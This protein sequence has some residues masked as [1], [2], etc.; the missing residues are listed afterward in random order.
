MHR[1]TESDFWCDDMLSRYGRA[2]MHSERGGGAG[3][4]TSQ[5]WQ[6]GSAAAAACSW[7]RARRRDL[8]VVLGTPYRSRLAS[9]GVNA[10]GFTGPQY[11]TFRGPSMCWTPTIIPTQSRVRCTIFIIDFVVSAV[12]EQVYSSTCK[13]MKSVRWNASLFTSKCTKTRL[14]V[15]LC[16]DPLGELTALPRSPSWVKWKGNRKGGKEGGTMRGNREGERKREDPQCL[17]CVDAN[18]GQSISLTVPDRIVDSYM[19]VLP[20]DS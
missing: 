12:V 19:F 5:G 6:T 10:A 8:P 15:R 18:A 4:V 16:P 3:R 1:L 2:Y 20:G 9:R 14:V 17:K 11:L 13:F 7:T